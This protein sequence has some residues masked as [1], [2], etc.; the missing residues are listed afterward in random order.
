MMMRTFTLLFHTVLA[1]FY[2]YTATVPCHAASC[3]DAE[4]ARDAEYYDATCHMRKR[5]P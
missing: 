2:L 1:Y 4:Y 5:Q 3:R